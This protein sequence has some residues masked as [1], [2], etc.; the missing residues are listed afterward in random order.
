M[1]RIRVDHLWIVFVQFLHLCSAQVLNCTV[2]LVAGGTLY[3]VPAFEASNCHYWWTNVTNYVLANHMSKMDKLV[4]MNT[5]RSLL[6]QSC[7][8]EIHYRRNCIS[9]GIEYEANCTTSCSGNPDPQSWK[10]IIMVIIAAVVVVFLL[11]VLLCYKKRK[12]IHSCGNRRSNT[13]V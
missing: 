8:E 7:S 10:E 4:A 5:N 9:E 3:S 1:M 2:T 13:I 12:H 11:I 6:T